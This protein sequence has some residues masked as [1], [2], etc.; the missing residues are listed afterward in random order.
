MSK[1]VRVDRRDFIKLSATAVSGLILGVHV[2]SG[3]TVAEGAT[4]ELKPNV[5]VAIDTDG[6]V[7]IWMPRPEMGQGS[8]TGLTM[9]LADELEA[10]WDRI[11]LIQALAGPREVWGSMSAGGSTSIRQFWGPMGDAGAA[12][13]QMLV[14]AAAAHWGVPVETCRAE[15]HAVHRGTSGEKLAYGDLVEAAARL[16]VPQEVI[17]KDPSEF[18]YIGTSIPRLDIPSKVDGSAVFGF[19]FRLPGMKFATVRRCPVFG[20][21]L[22]GFDDTETLQVNGVEQ[23]VEFSEGV[24][25][26]ARSSWAAM[27]GMDALVID[28]DEGPHAG[29]SSDDI[30]RQLEQAANEEPMEAE[31]TGDPHSALEHAAKKISAV[32]ECG[33]VSHSPMEPM[34][35]TAHVHEDSCDVWVPT[36]APQTCQ[37]SAASALGMPT[38]NVRVHT[39]MTGGAFGRRLNGDYA[40]DAVQISRSIGGPVQVFWTRTEDTQHGFYRPISRH[41]ME[42]A[43]DEAGELT[44]WRHKVVAHSTSGAGNPERMATRV[45]TGALAGA[46]RL[47][48]RWP[49]SLIEWKMSNTPVPTGPWRSVYAAQGYFA[50]EGFI[51]EVAAE[52]DRDPFEF[53]MNLEEDPRIREVLRVAAEAIGWGRETPPGTGLGIASGFCFGG[54]LAHAVEVTVDSRNRIKVNRVESAIDSGWV[55]NPDS[56]AAQVEGGVILALQTVLHHGITLLNG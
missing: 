35:A 13:R 31:R 28:W 32:Y 56:V 37:N 17:R 20:G 5:F 41:H 33:F 49:S 27:K 24:A 47:T 23:V 12:A 43:F 7:T 40:A 44:A 21:R 3:E 34:N 11:E 45:D 30:A 42:A 14:A 38:E 15:G 50:T 16:P 19:D 53:R 55:V 39:L 10:D 29:L 9:I 54:R 2:A 4:A 36:Q 1:V 52:L 51:D 22:R 8:R 48:Y 25:V 46:R 6:K 26:V 18:R